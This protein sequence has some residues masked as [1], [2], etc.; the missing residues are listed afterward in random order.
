[1]TALLLSDIHTAITSIEQLASYAGELMYYQ[2]PGSLQLTNNEGQRINYPFAQ[3]FQF[4]ADDQRQYRRYEFIVPLKDDAAVTPRF[5]W[6]HTDQID[7]ASPLLFPE[8][9]KDASLTA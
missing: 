5:Q 6:M 8:A 9:Y 7:K 4:E 1:M 3:V 2:F